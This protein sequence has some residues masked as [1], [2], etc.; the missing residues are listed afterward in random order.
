MEEHPSGPFA[1]G[2][3]RLAAPFLIDTLDP[4]RSSLHG[5]TDLFFDLQFN[6]L[7]HWETA[8]TGE[9]AGDLAESLPEHPDELTYVFRLRGGVPFDP[10]PPTEG[11]E[12]TAGDLLFTLRRLAEQPTTGGVGA[13]SAPHAAGSG[14]LE[15]IEAPD[16][17]TVILQLRRPCP[18]FLALLMLPCAA[19]VAPESLPDGFEGSD[20]ELLQLRGTGPFLPTA[21]DRARGASYRRHPDYFRHPY[22]LLDGLELV[23]LAEVRLI[24]AALREKRIDAVNL[25]SR[26]VQDRTLADRLVRELRLESLE[27][28]CGEAFQTLFSMTGPPYDDERVRRALSLAIDRPRI[29]AA[30][31]ARGRLSEWVPWF[32]RDAALPSGE[33]TLMPGYRTDEAGRSQ[34]LETAR[35]LWQAAGAPELGLT[36]LWP[37]ADEPESSGVVQA[38]KAGMRE[39]LNLSV[40][41]VGGTYSQQLR[42]WRSKPSM[43]NLVG[44]RPLSADGLVQLY[45]ALHSSFARQHGYGDPKVDALLDKAALEPEEEAR[46]ALLND[47]L[48]PYLFEHVPWFF[49]WFHITL[50][51]LSWPYFHAFDPEF[52]L[53]NWKLERVWLD[54]TDRSFVGRPGPA[55]VLA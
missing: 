39:G 1:G 47:Q 19:V 6:R 45:A 11:R 34:D 44:H 23:R 7:L 2:V 50:L 37:R 18:P 42:S 20:A 24:E 38:L 53:Q 30:T 41:P 40:E 35:L 26:Q 46:T 25:T 43:W 49:N 3:G 5:G 32:F 36:A 4:H 13:W 55:V 29:L 54:P 52:G 17:S 21:F 15:R 27:A 22:P 48:K 33:L 12:L 14:C 16:P 9:A 28:P 31:A 51:V 10:R 8:I